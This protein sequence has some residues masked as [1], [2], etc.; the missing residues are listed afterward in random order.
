ME[1]KNLYSAVVNEDFER[2]LNLGIGRCTI[3]S[4]AC[5]ERGNSEKGGRRG[6][7]L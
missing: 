4:P 7:G 1:A 6:D 3:F 2:N 5:K